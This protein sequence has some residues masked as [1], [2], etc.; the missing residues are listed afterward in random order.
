MT[1]LCN[2]VKYSRIPVFFDSRTFPYSGIFYA[3]LLTRKLSNFSLLPTN[4][5]SKHYTRNYS[6]ENFSKFDFILDMTENP[7]LSFRNTEVLKDSIQNFWI[8]VLTSLHRKIPWKLLW[9]CLNPTLA[10]VSILYPM[11]T[12]K[13]IFLLVFSGRMKRKHL[14]EIG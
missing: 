3:A 14:S 8:Y 12:P 10:N 13:N 6:E 11:K 1:D 4:K 2:C 9:K 7:R 5:V